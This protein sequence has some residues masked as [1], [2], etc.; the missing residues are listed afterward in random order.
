VATRLASDDLSMKF[1]T[2]ALVA[3]LE[4]DG[5]PGGSMVELVLTAGLSG[6]HAFTGRDWPS[7]SSH[8]GPEFESPDGS[9][10][11][12]R[13]GAMQC[14]RLSRGQPAAGVSP[15]AVN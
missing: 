6:R 8:Q 9:S 15:R 13:A 11:P 14:Q 2:Q 3:A 5:L 7:N 4:L 12:R 1:D 10:A